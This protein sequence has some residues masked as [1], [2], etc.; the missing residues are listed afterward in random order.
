MTE[1]PLR[2]AGGCLCGGVR[3]EIRGELRP[4]LACHCTQCARTSGHYVSATECRTEDFS[5]V[6]AGTLLWYQSSEAAE[7]G[8]CR[9]CGG[10]LFWRMMGGDGISVMA[11]TLDRPTFLKTVE[12]IHVASKSDYYEI[13]D[14]LPRQ[15][16]WEA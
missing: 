11:G 3:Y 1:R 6:E 9:T 7:R 16:D 4:V 14:G 12:H 10:N 8:F 15:Q 5:L 2:A 13:A